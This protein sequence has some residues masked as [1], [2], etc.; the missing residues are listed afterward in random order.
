MNDG[1]KF[2]RG[3]LIAAGFTIALLLVAVIVWLF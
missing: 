1:L 3:M 2:F